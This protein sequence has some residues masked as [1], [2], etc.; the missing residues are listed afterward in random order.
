VHDICLQVRLLHVN[1]G[2]V[3]EAELSDV[4]SFKLAPGYDRIDMPDGLQV[5]PAVHVPPRASAHMSPS[6][7]LQ[8]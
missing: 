3:L 6:F 7:T 2:R 1:W 8:P 4:P 5:R